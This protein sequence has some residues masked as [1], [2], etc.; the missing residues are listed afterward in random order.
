MITHGLFPWFLEGRT[1]ERHL[2]SSVT[3]QVFS[4]PAEYDIIKIPFNPVGT[5]EAT[6]TWVEVMPHGGGSPP[7]HPLAS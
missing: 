7:C 5:K 4:L 2:L 3:P 1:K 6:S